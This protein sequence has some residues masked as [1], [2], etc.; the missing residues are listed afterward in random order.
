MG[1]VLVPVPEQFVLDVMRWVLRRSRAIAPFGAGAHGTTPWDAAAIAQLLNE[2]DDPSRRLLG[3]VATAARDGREV[4][5]GEAERELELD[6]GEQLLASYGLTVAPAAAD[7]LR[8]LGLSD[9]PEAPADEDPNLL[10]HYL[11]SDDVV[12]LLTSADSFEG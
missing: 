2:L 11:I 5:V 1:F 4:T 8:L 10:R 7:R 6:A 12:A 9:A 3:F